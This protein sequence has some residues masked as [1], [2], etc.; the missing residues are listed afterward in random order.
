[1]SRA[2]P[3]GG[4]KDSPKLQQVGAVFTE[5]CAARLAASSVD[6]QVQ[7]MLSECTAGSP[8]PDAD[9]TPIQLTLPTCCQPVS[10]WLATAPLFAHPASLQL[11]LADT[12]WQELSAAK[13]RL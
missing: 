13:L 11:P 6:V 7:S 12:A 5:R 2:C 10:Q 3:S 1:M 4:V 8:G 9:Q